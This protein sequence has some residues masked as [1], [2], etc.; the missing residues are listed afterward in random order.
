MISKTMI[1]MFVVV[2]S[3]IVTVGAVIPAYADQ[4]RIEKLQTQIQKHE[5]RIQ[6]LENKKDGSN[7]ANID[8]RIQ[9]LQD[10]I[11]DKQAI[12]ERLTDAIAN[13]PVPDIGPTLTP[14]DVSTAIF[15]DSFSVR[16]Q[17]GFPRGLA[18]SADGGK[19]FVVAS[20]SRDVKEYTLSVPF[21]VST[22]SFVDS[23]SVESQD[24]SP[25]GLAF[26]TNGDKMFVV[27]RDGEDVNEYTLSVPFDV[28]TAVFVD[29][30]LPAP[31][32]RFPIGLA[33]ST[34]GD[35]MFVLG[36]GSRDV[37]EYILLVPFD[38]ST[39]SFVDSFSVR[40][41]DTRPYDLAFSTNGYKMFVVGLTDNDVN[42]YTLT[43]PFDVSTASFFDSFSVAS[44]EMRP[45]GL[46]FSADGSKM[47]VTGNNNE[48]HEYVLTSDRLDS[49]DLKL[50]QKIQDMERVIRDMVSQM[51]EM[52]SHITE[53]RNE[54]MATIPTEHP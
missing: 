39:A 41:Q 9:R 35:K 17:D 37:N 11:A 48:V 4:E 2:V 6:V 21:D 42:E 32:V 53:M 51:N 7:D 54:L 8:E 33:F 3:M 19:M 31:P 30:F 14:F 10:K 28:S 46:A 26:S 49:T 15:V 12:I 38:V 47:F 27:G 13:T 52:I 24:T 25:S 40:L 29:S 5:D 22:A 36:I 43:T 18:F 20:I 1:L 23:F 50:I 16:L 44:Q 34:D 45:L